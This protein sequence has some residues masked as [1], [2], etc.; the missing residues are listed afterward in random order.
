MEDSAIVELFWTRSETARQQ[1]RQACY[2]SME[3]LVGR[4]VYNNLFAM[5]LLE[6]TR[7]LLGER[8]VDLAALEDNALALW[9]ASYRDDGATAKLYYDENVY[10]VSK[11]ARGF[12]EI[13]QVG[14]ECLGAVDDYVLGEV[15]L[16][17][18]ESLRR[19]SGESLLRISHLGIVG[20]M[21]DELGLTGGARKAALR[22]LGGKNLH[23][24]GAVCREAGVP[25]AGIEKLRRHAAA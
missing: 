9:N 25:E 22:C 18:A 10:R 14:L 16:L 4:L 11:S 3:Y 24:L 20:S 21:L 23:E 7:R 5:G 2:L 13:R 12:R 1:G 6:E 19:I 8:G 17:A 15:L